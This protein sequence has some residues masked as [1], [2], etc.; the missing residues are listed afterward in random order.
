M[1]GSTG[2]KDSFLFL[3]YKLTLEYTVSKNKKR[4][5]TKKCFAKSEGRT[6]RVTSSGSLFET[7][8]HDPKWASSEDLSSAPCRPW[9]R[10]RSVPSCG[11]LFFWGVSVCECVFFCLFVC[12]TSCQGCCGLPL[13][14]DQLKSSQKPSLWQSLDAH[15][16]GEA[17]DGGEKQLKSLPSHLPNPINLDVFN[18]LS[19]TSNSPFLHFSLFLSE[20][21]FLS[22]S[23][24]FSQTLCLPPVK[25][26][27]W[28]SIA[29]A[30]KGHS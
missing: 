9:E 13:I 5:K 8:S 17:S 27:D 2:G 4:R 21:L 3:Y 23:L 6:V 11:M 28:I 7:A 18:T 15:S 24:F 1:Y 22:I 14:W 16:E 20:S 19:I 30:S 29:T 26:N 10:T 12:L 25:D